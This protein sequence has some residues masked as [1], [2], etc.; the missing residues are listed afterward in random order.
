MEKRTTEGHYFQKK[1]PIDTIR[2][3]VFLTKSAMLAYS[4]SKISIIVTAALATEVPGPKMPDT[5]AL[6]KKS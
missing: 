6:Y 1:Q 3:A 4:S 2:Q 5:P